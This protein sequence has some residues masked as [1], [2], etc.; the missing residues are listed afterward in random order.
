M[1]SRR[2]SGPT[3]KI[4]GT[5]T[6]LR[7]TSDDGMWSVAELETDDGRVVTVVGAL[8]VARIGQHVQA[9]GRWDRHAVFGRQFKLVDIDARLPV[10][11]EGMEKYLAHSQAHGVG[12]VLAKRLVG[13]FGPDILEVIENT[14]ERLTEVEGIGK[15]RLERIVGARKEHTHEEEAFEKVRRFLFSYGVSKAYH[16]RIKKKYG[17]E[18]VKRVTSNPYSLARDIHGVGFQLADKVAGKLGIKGDDPRRIRAGVLHALDAAA[19]EGHLYLPTDDLAERSCDL[20]GT[21]VTD[22]Q[23]RHQ[24]EA[25]CT[26]GRLVLEP[27]PEASHA[28]IFSKRSH[29]SEQAVATE[30]GRLMDTALGEDVDPADMARVEF[31]LGVTL[32]EQQ[33]K[34]VM[35]AFTEAVMVITGG[36]GTGKTTLVRAI[37]ELAEVMDFQILLAAPTGR[38]AKRMLEATGREAKTLHRLLEFSWMAGG[39]QRGRDNPLE[40]DIIVIDESSMLDVYLAQAVLLAIPDGCITVF[41]GDVDQLPSVGPGDVLHDLIKSGEV[42]VVKLDTVFRQSE[43]SGIVRNAHRVNAGHPPERARHGQQTDFYFI[44]ATDAE[45]ALD[46]TLRVVTQRAPSAFGFD[47]IADVQVL[48]PMKKGAVG[49]ENLNIRLQELLNPLADGERQKGPFRPGDRVMQMFNDYDKEVFNGDVGLVRTAVASGIVVDMD[50]RNVE[51][52]RDELDMLALAYAVTAHKSQGSEYPAVVIPLITGHY[53]M[54]QRNLLY[55]AITR[56]KRLV[57]LIGMER[58]V[59]R[60][61]GNVDAR[62]RYTRLAARLQD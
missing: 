53:M 28:A 14:P 10:T 29:R 26:E 30:L 11:S 9:E 37:C 43:A 38:A 36:P 40:A 34:A 58:A 20:L 8:G 60:A 47:P 49:T 4:D 25:L 22:P 54:L 61:V 33:R 27:A 48:A 45:D 16:A 12:P 1:A 32:A 2:P 59:K 15:V 17:D 24:I 18:V 3:E 56:A 35:R 21:V 42:P 5:L 41:V 44:P 52:G 62:L 46:K 51:Y 6:R 55:T 7:H 31:G 39:F 13:H 57:V 50:G 19:S 23:V